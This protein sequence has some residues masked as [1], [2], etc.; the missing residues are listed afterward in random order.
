MQKHELF[1]W[2]G[3]GIKSAADTGLHGC[4]LNLSHK[5]IS[6]VLGSMASFFSW[7][8]SIVKEG[9]APGAGGWEGLGDLG[10]MGSRVCS[11]RHIA[12]SHSR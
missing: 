8:F 3:R 11:R 1:V 9:R 10:P 7:A 5:K 2:A 4:Q 12:G 6:S